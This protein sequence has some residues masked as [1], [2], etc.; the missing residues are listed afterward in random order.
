[1]EPPIV[2]IVPST[3]RWQSRGRK[4]CLHTQFP[5]RVAYAVTIHK[6]QRMTLSKAIVELGNYDFIRGLTF[7]AISRVRGIEDIVFQLEIWSKRLKKLGGTTNL[8][9]EDII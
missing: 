3:I 7:V 1:M 4:Q 5:L 8:L 9:N 2:P 6:S